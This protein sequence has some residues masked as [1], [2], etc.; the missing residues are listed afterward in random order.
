MLF[1]SDNGENTDLAR[2]ARQQKVIAAIKNEVLS[3]QNLFNPITD[4]KLYRI[5]KNTVETDI[6]QKAGIILA[7][8][9]HWARNNIKSH[10]FPIELL[11]NPPISAKYDNQYIFVPQAGDWDKVKIWVSELLN[12]E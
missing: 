11:V 12:R 1:R 8:K 9:F 7:Q 10:V 5:S 3:P 6:D 2:E 4:L